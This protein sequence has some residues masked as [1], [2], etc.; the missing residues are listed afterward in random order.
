MKTMLLVTMLAAWAVTMGCADIGASRV[1]DVYFKGEP[2]QT[3]NLDDL[4]TWRDDTREQRCAWWAEDRF[5]M[6][7]HW[8]I[9]AVPAGTYQDKQI[10]GIGEWIMRRGSI[11]VDEYR[12]YAKQ[13]NPVKYDPD[14]WVRLAKDAG[15]K[16]IVITAKH[17]DGFALFDSKVTTWDVVDAS[18]YGKDLIKPLAEACRKHGIKFGLYYSQAQD[19]NHPG[20]AASGGH[21]D[22]KQ[23]GSM[24]QYIDEIA[25]PQVKEILTNYGPLGILWWDTPKDMTKERASRLYPL[26]KL[27]PH[28]ITNNRLGGGFQGDY[29]TPEQKI[30]KD[31]PKNNWETCMTMNKTWGFK[32][33]DH[34][35]KSTETLIH[36]LVDIISKGGNYLLNVGPTAEGLIPE[37]SV[38][39][40]EE[41]G[42]WMKVN[43]ASIYGCGVGPFT[44]APAWGRVTAKGSRLYLHVFDPPTS[45]TITLPALKNEIQSARLLADPQRKSLKVTVADNTLKV[46][47][48]DNLPNPI[49]TVIVL[50]VK[51]EPGM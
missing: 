27:Q 43:G 20:G 34:D 37:A 12:E 2:P 17:H 41:I 35:W 21:W 22:K 33:Y 5:G 9:Y 26:V 7:I 42:T 19:W 47:L 24:D 30:P 44:E 48:P 23:D 6:F 40:L 46:A 18:P 38:Q 8:G 15:M 49:D 28:I 45:G 10:P 50:D 25:V 3:D 29:G 1:S 4:I 51:G 36:N 16:Y 31:K 39:R 13:F 32:S 11:P 14:A